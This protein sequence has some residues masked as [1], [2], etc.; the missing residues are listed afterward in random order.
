M[1]IPPHTT[2]AACAKLL[3]FLRLEWRAGVRAALKKYQIMS[4]SVPLV[5]LGNLVVASTVSLDESC[6]RLVRFSVETSCIY[7]R[8]RRGCKGW[9]GRGWGD[10][11]SPTI[12]GIINVIEE[13]RH[14]QDGIEASRGVTA[15]RVW[16]KMV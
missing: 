4:P 16:H 5:L 12:E 11:T 13:E 14:I 7:Q 6:L 9:D 15:V 8:G 1:Y 2:C 10:R 3:P